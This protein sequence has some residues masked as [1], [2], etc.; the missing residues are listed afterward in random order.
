MIRKLV[1]RIAETA[2]IALAAY[3]FFCVPIGR[4]TLWKH[5]VA[6][7]ST[8]PAREAAEDLGQAGKQLRDK[9]TE[10]LKANSR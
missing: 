5:V 4:Q 7:F 9:I 2:V 10:P 8:Q 6:I 3:T 1:V